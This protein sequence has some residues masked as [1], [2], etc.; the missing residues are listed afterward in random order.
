MIPKENT[1]LLEFSK[2]SN[3]FPLTT[4]IKLR[5]IIFVRIWCNC[6]ETGSK[7]LESFLIWHHHCVKIVRIRSYSGP[8]FPAFGLNTERYSV[9][10][11]IQSECG[12]IRTRITPNTD[13]FYVVRV[14]CYILQIF[15]LITGLFK[16]FS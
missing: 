2:I 10:L 5:R 13:T 15:Y 9:S 6:W 12:K 16:V 3:L 1:L 11:R 7:W 4:L 8:H 14:A